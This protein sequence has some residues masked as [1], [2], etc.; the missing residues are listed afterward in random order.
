M[1]GVVSRIGGQQVAPTDGRA[2]DSQAR[3]YRTSGI[4][5]VTRSDPQSS[6]GDGPRR[7]LRCH[8]CRQT[9]ESTSEIL[10]R[11]TREGWPKCCGQVMALFTEA[12]L[13]DVQPAD[14]PPG[15]RVGM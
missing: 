10:L 4:S 13:P 5:V 3:R 11:Y 8:S 1:R 15:G 2:P 14:P 9:I 7:L 12:E 6:R